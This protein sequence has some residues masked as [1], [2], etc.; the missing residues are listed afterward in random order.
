MAGS[1]TLCTKSTEKLFVHA[2]ETYAIDIW[3]RAQKIG[4]KREDDKLPGKRNNPTITTEKF[5]SPAL[6]GGTGT[7]VNE[8]FDVSEIQ[9]QESSSIKTIS[10]PGERQSHSFETTDE[11]SGTWSTHSEWQKTY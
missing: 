2:L 4:Q 3:M 1:Y 10:A 8:F 5:E 7:R 9:K 11:F 6:Y